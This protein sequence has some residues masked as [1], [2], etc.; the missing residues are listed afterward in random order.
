MLR[1]SKKYQI[2]ICTYDLTHTSHNDLANSHRTVY[3][4]Q[5][6][7]SAV[8]LSK[9]KDRFWCEKVINKLWYCTRPRR[10]WPYI[11]PSRKRILLLISKMPY[12]HLNKFD[13]RPFWASVIF[14]Y[15]FSRTFALHNHRHICT[16]TNPL[17]LYIFHH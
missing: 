7:F 9:I 6:K 17:H 8:C 11:A 3:W 2:S 10:L 5:I 13:K 15:L 12:I 16:G 1:Q 14:D 4:R